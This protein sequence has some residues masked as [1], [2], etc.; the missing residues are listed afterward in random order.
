VI[1][2]T[3]MAG[4]S[5]AVHVEVIDCEHAALARNGHLAPRAEPAL[6][7]PTAGDGLAGIVAGPA[8]G[9]AVVAAATSARI[10]RM[11]TGI[12]APQHGRRL[13]T[14]PTAEK[15]SWT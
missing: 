9:G 12:G 4:D 2:L 15:V 14:P 1:S 8:G 7:T 6:V 11:L 13:A 3:P 10:I 5:F